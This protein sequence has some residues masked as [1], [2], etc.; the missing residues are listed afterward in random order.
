[1]GKK[2]NFT[3]KHVDEMTGRE[4]FCVERLR[5]DS[6]V[7]EQKITLPELDDIDLK[8]IQVY[9]LNKHKN[10]ALATCRVFQANGKWMLGRVAVAKKMRGQHI[11][12]DMMHAVHTFLRQKDVNYL[13]CHAQLQ[14]KPFYVHLNYHVKGDTFDEGGVQHILM[15]KNLQ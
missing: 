15:Y 3:F 9:L 2:L 8:A 6:F 1:V 12:A 7:T 4:F 5:T 10:N 11:G 13:Y 14:A